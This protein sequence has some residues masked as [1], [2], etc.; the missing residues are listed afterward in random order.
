M[1]RQRKVLIVD[2]NPLVRIN[3]RVMLQGEEFVVFTEEDRHEAL[4]RISREEF[5]LVITDIRLPNKYHGLSAVQEIRAMQPHAD[6]VVTADQPSIWDA[7][8]A[9]RLGAFGY[10]EK[11]F[12]PEFVM[13]VAKRAFDK[14]GWIMKKAAID[15][16]RDYTIPGSVKDNPTIYYKDG[17][18][19]RYLNEDLWE[20]GCDMKY[21]SSTGCGDH[22][23]SITLSNDVF[24]LA[25]GEPYSRVTTGTKKNYELKA[26]MAGMVI[27]FNKKANDILGSCAPEYLGTEWMLWLTRI[28]T[29]EAGYWNIVDIEEENFA[30]IYGLA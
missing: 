1:E 20:V 27:E 30:G 16:F 3:C 10:I 28:Q 19:A 24:K 7:R 4:K 23:F 21:L 26:P 12:V 5:D 17:V 2:V 15:H 25:A 29:K 8:E 13:N 22:A 6:I 14:N 9:V 11:P 18:W